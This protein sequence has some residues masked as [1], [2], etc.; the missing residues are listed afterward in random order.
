LSKLDLQLALVTLCP[1]GEDIKY[2][3]NAVHHATL[4]GALEV[5]LLCRPQGLIEQNDAGLMFRDLVGDFSDLAGPNEQRR[6]RTIAPG[7]NMF[8]NPGAGAACQQEELIGMGGVVGIT[9]IDPDDQRAH[10]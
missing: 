3:R 8:N 4:E 9:E 2:K 5:A 6:V 1:Q 10:G 7:G